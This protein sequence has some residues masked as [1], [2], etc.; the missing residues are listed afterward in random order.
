MCIKKWANLASQMKFLFPEI[1][2]ALAALAIPVI[3]HLFNFRKFRKVDFPNVA[4]LKEIKQETQSKSK[5]KHLLILLSRLLAM[6]AIIFAFAQPYIPL[7]K[8][9]KPSQGKVVSI[10][11]DNSFSMQGESEEGPLFEV[12]KNKAME[13]V[14]SFSATD[15]FQLLTHDFEGRHQRLVNKDEMLEMLGETAI[16]SNHHS[17]SEIIG[18]QFD[19]VNEAI[20]D[21][22][23]FVIGDMQ[24]SGLD[25]E[26]CPTDTNIQVVLV[27]TSNVN[28]NNAWLDSIWFETPVRQLNEPERLSF[29]LGASGE[30]A[31]ED[32]PVVFN[33]NGLQK[34]IGSTPADPLQLI[35]TT[36]SFSNTTT[37]WMKASIEIT[38]HPITFD[39]RFY[40]SYE[41]ADKIN[42]LELKAKDIIRD[43][44]YNLFSDDPFFRFEAINEGLVDFNSFPE[45]DLII[46]NQFRS[47]SSG[48]NAELKKFSVN[49]GTV[50]V[51][52][53]SNA[54]VSGY[55]L[56]LASIGDDL[57]TAKKNVE[58]KVGSI[59]LEHYLYKGVFEKAPQN[60]DLPAILG[61]FPLKRT[62]RSG[63]EELMSSKT[64]DPYLIQYE[65]GRGRILLFCTSLDPADGNLAQHALFPAT[66]L[67]VAEFAQSRT[68]LS[69]TIGEDQAI[70]LRQIDIQS[71]QVLK[72]VSDESGAEFIPEH[73]QSG[74]STMVYVHS[75]IKEA[76]HYTLL[77]GTDTVAVVAF[78]QNRL[79]SDLQAL[80]EDDLKAGIEE[81]ELNYRVLESSMESITKEVSD[82][83]DGKKL[84]FIMIVLAL[85][86]LAI[87]ILLIKFWK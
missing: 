74:G 46:V 80:D 28:A 87:E 59:N 12:A 53:A 19:A 72:M 15:R 51:I 48:L 66:V 70:D 45:F 4:F 83:S 27:P 50:L 24:K 20:G 17:L 75:S 42:V 7:E 76:G 69:Y 21:K 71:E 8:N 77:N 61:I 60:I 82:L 35:D 52:P 43:P 31:M 40:F 26:Q 55:N 5:I 85:I 22:S 79:E 11:L 41:V 34:A 30:E 9:S 10:F 86:F 65:T 33:I 58:T 13:I 36:L 32:I 18:R 68:R 73:R 56:L 16:S 38:D 44:F 3:V 64:A 62:S 1:L 6:A 81:S 49:G 14:E 84:W 23:V 25:F 29:R 47:L 57:L 37:G 39:N 63:S 54:D 2:Y 78:N 67:R